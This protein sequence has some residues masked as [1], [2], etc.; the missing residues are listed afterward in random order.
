MAMKKSVPAAD[1]D[2]YIAALSGWRRDCA[3]GLRTAVQ[4][5]AP[6]QEVIK[7][8]HLV[9]FSNGPVLLIRVEENRVLFGFWRGKRLRAIEPRLKPG[10][11]YE[12]ATFELVE[13]TPWKPAVVS[14]LVREAVALNA[15]AGDPT[16]SAPA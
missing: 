13:G 8:G 10:G 2:A 14:R 1:P 7:W 6:L 9:Y 5:A 12:L 11:K 3:E 15:S 4:K 16:K